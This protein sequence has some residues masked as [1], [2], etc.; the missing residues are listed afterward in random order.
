MKRYITA[1]IYIR[2]LFDLSKDNLQIKESK[3]QGVNL[4][5]VSEVRMLLFYFFL[6]LLT[7]F[8]SLHLMLIL[9]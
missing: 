5:A 1:N 6:I 3:L 2:D 7:R 8:I 4:S 9:S